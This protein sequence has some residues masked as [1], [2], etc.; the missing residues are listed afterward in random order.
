MKKEKLRILLSLVALVTLSC[1]ENQPRPE[2][3]TPAHTPP[4]VEVTN[5]WYSGGTLHRGNAI[6]WQNA[7]YENKLATVADFVA[8]FYRDRSFVPAI[9]ARVSGF[10]ELRPIAEEFV[11]E[12]DAVFQPEPDPAENVQL[13]QNQKISETVALI[14]VMN[15]WLK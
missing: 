12:L 8:T 9:Q 3:R 11:K 2:T 1:S 5:R 4:P 10:E 13:F 14:G 7:S 15:N 6:D